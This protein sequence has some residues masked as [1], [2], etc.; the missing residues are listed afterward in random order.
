[1]I[2][3]ELP[4]DCAITLNLT[5][6]HQMDDGGPVPRALRNA[7]HLIKGCSA[8]SPLPTAAV[9]AIDVV[10]D[11]NVCVAP[12]YLFGDKP[13]LHGDAA[14]RFVLASTFAADLHERLDA[15]GSLSF[16]NKIRGSSRKYSENQILRI[17]AVFA[18]SAAGH[19]RVDDV[20]KASSILLS[21]GSEPRTRDAGKI[22]ARMISP[23]NAWA[24][25]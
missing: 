12:R 1:M 17:L 4:D 21:I 8:H 23:I 18:L 10:I 14:R 11:S 24:R 13:A 16:L 5:D 22:S 25:S 7:L 6:R 3:F 20:P 2:Q 19:D 9:E 15:I